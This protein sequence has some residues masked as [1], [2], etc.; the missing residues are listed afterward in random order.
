MPHALISM[1]KH[2][3][4]AKLKEL[5]SNLGRVPRRDEYTQIVREYDYKKSFGTFTALLH[6][7]GF[8]G[9][10][11]A[12]EHKKEKVK[13]KFKKSIIE[14]F[15]INEID[16]DEIFKAAGNPEVLKFIVQPDTHV[17]NRNTEAVKIF[18]DFCRWYKPN[19]HIILGDF[20]DAEGISHWPNASL[21]PRQFIPEVIEARELLS[22]IVEATPDC[23]SRIFLTGN[24]EDW[25]SQAMAHKMPEFFNGLDEL[26]LLP[27]LKK[28]LDLEKF[29]Y[30]LLPVNEILK[31]GKA[32]FTHGLYVG[33]NH[34]KKHLDTI[35][36]NIYYGH[37]HDVLSTHQP[38]I[39]GFME[40]VSLGCLC[41]VD[42]PFMK[43]KPTNWV[44]SFG[45]FEF[46]KDGSY[47][48]YLNRIFDN[49]MSFNGKVFRAVETN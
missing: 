26:G 28:L 5:A 19:A 23:I 39:G 33:N 45:V 22:A 15:K 11:L 27:D 1:D 43:G 7:A 29:G 17:K 16:L 47:S 48:F 46:F 41:R 10:E 34:P 25:I 36:G 35:K 2:D 6:A 40:A 4:V 20:L 38:S 37:L 3:L 32:H 42:A 49:K 13:F 14:S 18:I 12:K 21:E 24:H 31:I 8:K 9:K 44:N 30:E